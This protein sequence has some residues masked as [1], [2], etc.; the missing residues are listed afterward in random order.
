[1]RYLNCHDSEIW[2]INCHAKS[3]TNELWELRT[4]P[5]IVHC[6]THLHLSSFISFRTLFGNGSTTEDLSNKYSDSFLSAQFSDTTSVHEMSSNATFCCKFVSVVSHEIRTGGCGLHVDMFV[7]INY[8]KRHN[9]N[10]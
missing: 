7:C 6:Q 2:L 10:N 8:P 5:L 4:G 1:M 3:Y 9:Y